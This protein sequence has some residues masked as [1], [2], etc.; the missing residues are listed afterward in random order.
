MTRSGTQSV[1]FARRGSNRA[2]RHA[3]ARPLR[4]VVVGCVGAAALLR[5]V[6]VF[7]SLRSQR[8]ADDCRLGDPG[9]VLRV[10]RPLV[11][12]LGD[13]ARR[14]QFGLRTLFLLGLAVAVPLGWLH[15]ELKNAQQR[16]D[17]IKAIFKRHRATILYYYQIDKSGLPI[18]NASPPGPA[19]LRAAVGDQILEGVHTAFVRSDADVNCLGVF[20]EIR[21][22]SS[23]PTTLPTRAWKSLRR[24]R[25]SSNY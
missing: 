7:Q 16:R 25:D 24:S 8:R 9:G 2:F 10:F 20:P 23:A 22:I 3:H 19:W 11:S 17:A 18:S 14:F 12:R 21:R 1:A 6:L 5:L 4:P 13:V 15:A